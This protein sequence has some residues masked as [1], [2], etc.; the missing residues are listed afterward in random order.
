M[1]EKNNQKSTVPGWLKWM[2]RWRRTPIPTPEP[3]LLDIL[4]KQQVTLEA[5]QANIEKMA[6]C[7]NEGGGHH[8][9]NKTY[10]MTGSEFR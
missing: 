4:R 9:H 1:I 10:F 3:E 6:K 7:V 5:I 2:G 8:P